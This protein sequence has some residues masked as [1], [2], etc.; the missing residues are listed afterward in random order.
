MPYQNISATLS[1]EDKEAI[2][3]AIQTI[4]EKLS[5]LVNLSVEE[6]RKLFKMGDKSLGFVQNSLNIAQ[7]NPDIL[8]NSFDFNEFVQDYKL[9][10]ALQEI[11]LELRQLEEKI[12]DTL[13]AVGSE[14]MA[15]SLEVYEYVKTA[16]KR[17]PGLKA[18][19]E[20]LG[21][22]FKAMKAKTPKSDG[23]SAPTS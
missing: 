8:P 9:A 13:L 2:K 15:S 4:E 20:E 6:R 12:D 19:A 23:G 3:A 21:E 18:A 11:F 1:D 7:S 22:R 17:T 16:A 10:L 5:F 14:A